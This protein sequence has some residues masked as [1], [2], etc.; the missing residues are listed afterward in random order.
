M[1]LY[2]GMVWGNGMGGWVEWDGRRGWA[3]SYGSVSGHP[4]IHQYLLQGAVHH[5]AMG[6]IRLGQSDY[7]N[8]VMSI[9]LCPSGYVHP[10]LS[11]HVF[12]F[13]LNHARYRYA[14]ATYPRW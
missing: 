1:R 5:P 6:L 8:R 4:Q 3:T 11:I 12:F 10:V 2:Q 13:L 9:R 14:A 7:V